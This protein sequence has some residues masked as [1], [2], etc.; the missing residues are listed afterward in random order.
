MAKAPKLLLFITMTMDG[1]DSISHQAIRL[2]WGIGSALLKDCDAYTAWE[3]LGR[4]VVNLQIRG[5]QWGHGKFLKGKAA[6]KL[7]FGQ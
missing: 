3:G 5:G 4:P 1:D 6:T 2:V 7:L